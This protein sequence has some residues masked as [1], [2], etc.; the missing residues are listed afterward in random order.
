LVGHSIDKAKLSGATIMRCASTLTAV[1]FYASLGFV[2]IGPIAAALGPGI[3]FEAV[4][5]Q[6]TI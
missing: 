3:T 1:P 6:L 5:M 4:D 2:V